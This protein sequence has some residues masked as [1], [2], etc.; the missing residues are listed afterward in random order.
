MK[1]IALGDAVAAKLAGIGVILDFQD[2]SSDVRRVRREK[3]LDVV[4]VDGQ[5]AVEPPYAA[6]GR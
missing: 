5:T 6:H 4:A 3:A 2:T 1:H